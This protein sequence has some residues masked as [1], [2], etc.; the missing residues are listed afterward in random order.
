ML[1]DVEVGYLHGQGG[2]LRAVRAAGPN[3]RREALNVARGR[4]APLQHGFLRMQG[5]RGAG[6]RGRQKATGG[7]EK[8]L[9]PSLSFFLPCKGLSGVSSKA[10]S[11]LCPQPLLQRLLR[12]PPR[13]PSWHEHQQRA[14]QRLQGRCRSLTGQGFKS[15]WVSLTHRLAPPSPSKR[16]CM[17]GRHGARVTREESTSPTPTPLL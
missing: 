15:P 4:E 16:S 6:R 3:F 2:V 5:E 17:L 8:A 14:A 9:V 10:F 12:P 11:R 13:P 1:C 7:Q